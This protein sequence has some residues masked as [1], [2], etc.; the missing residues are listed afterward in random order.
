MLR[1]LL[2][3][4]IMWALPVH[5]ATITEDWN[6]AN[7]TTINC[8]LTWTEVGGT[9]LEILSNRLVNASS[10]DDE[11]AYVANVL[12]ADVY[13]QVEVT[14]LTHHAG[15]VEAGGVVCRKTADAAVT[16]YYWEAT[17][18]DALNE[19]RLIE[20]VAGAETIL[21]T[22]TTDY[23]ALE[24]L[25]LECSGS[26]LRAYINGSLASFGAI[27][28]STISAAGRAGV[29]TFVNGATGEIQF[30]NFEAGDVA[31]RRA[32][33]PMPLGD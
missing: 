23:A 21:G 22:D 10:A 24:V 28:D 9:A 6:C 25:K 11:Q 31:S 32:S 26:T 1:L 12:T 13:V 8:D 19:H 30:D 3:L 16:G 29:F 7:S 4:L 17:R 2:V 5:A 27:T 33:A 14:S 20:R 18:T 15:A